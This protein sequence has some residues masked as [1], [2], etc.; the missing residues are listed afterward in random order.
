MKSLPNKT[1]LALALTALSGQV[2]AHGYVSEFD[3]GIAGSR[4]ALC[5]YPTTDTNE[6]NTNCGAIQY[7][8]Q[9][10][11]GP[12]GFPEAG[13]ADAKLLAHNLHWQQRLMSRLPIAG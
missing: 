5:K 9:S 7:E 6:K 11:E 8:P 1:L 13:P 4:A 12:E 10:V 2:A 3:G